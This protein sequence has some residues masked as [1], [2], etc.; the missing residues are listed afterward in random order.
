MLQAIY[1]QGVKVVLVSGRAYLEVAPLLQTLGLFQQP[2][3]T[4]NG[5]VVVQSSAGKII[6][7]D[8]IPSSLTYSLVCE[9]KDKRQSIVVAI[10]LDT[11]A[12]ETDAY[13]ELYTSFTS[14]EPTRVPDLREF[15]KRKKAGKICVC[16]R[17]RDLRVISEYLEN[18]YGKK[19]RGTFSM[20]TFVEFHV[21]T[22]SKGVA[23]KRLAD[24]YGVNRREVIAFGD[25]ENDITMLEYAGCGV[26]MGNAMPALKAVADRI[27]AS[28]N[29][30]GIALILEEFF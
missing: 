8:S 14:R 27:T 6:F 16:G 9:L 11:Y 30:D 4:L 29:E 19:I 21:P 17:E 5:A 26:A 20:P 1:E 22:V 15:T 18:K 10:D 13:L 25:G 23:L 7:N 12:D 2:V 3:I 24:Y 28:N